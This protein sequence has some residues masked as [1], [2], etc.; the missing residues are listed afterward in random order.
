MCGSRSDEG[1][2][3]VERMGAVAPENIEALEA[4]ALRR[5][6]TIS[7]ETAVHLE[8]LHV[9]LAEFN[10]AAGKLSQILGCL[11]KSREHIL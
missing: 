6:I 3:V 9:A 11:H 10:G 4:G 5:L 8:R 2:Q 7:G 1:D